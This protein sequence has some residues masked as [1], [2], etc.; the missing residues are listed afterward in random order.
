MASFNEILQCSLTNILLFLPLF[1]I[2]CSIFLAV[3]TSSFSLC[4]NFLCLSLNLFPVLPIYLSSLYN[5]SFFSPSLFLFFLCP[6]FV[7]IL[8][9]SHTFFLAL[10]FLL[11]FLFVITLSVCLTFSLSFPPSLLYNSYFSLPFS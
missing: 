9:L 3:P 5:T 2:S 7:D 6:Y 10:F 11:Y 8:P 4:F 1:F